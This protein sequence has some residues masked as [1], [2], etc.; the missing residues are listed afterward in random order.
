MMNIL[1]LEETAMLGSKVKYVSSM[2]LIREAI[3][4]DSNGQQPYSIS[5]RI[6]P[7]DQISALAV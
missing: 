7:I 5:K 6:T 4:F 1:V 2:V 3:E